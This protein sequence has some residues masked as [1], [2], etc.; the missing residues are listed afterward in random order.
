MNKN[1][2]CGPCNEAI[3]AMALNPWANQY[4]GPANN[5]GWRHNYYCQQRQA[6]RAMS[7]QLLY[8]DVYG[9][10][11]SMLRP[12][13]WRISIQV[14][15][16]LDFWTGR[17]RQKMQVML[18]LGRK[19]CLRIRHRQVKKFGKNFKETSFNCILKM[20]FHSS[21]RTRGGAGLWTRDLSTWQ[22][23]HTVKLN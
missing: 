7:S 22:I 16:K 3:M 5:G 10:K 2:K 14:K 15:L 17:K 23:T 1:E 4:T 8:L 12:N 21:R 18:Y 6:G 20:I 19:L 9:Y 11:W 13:L